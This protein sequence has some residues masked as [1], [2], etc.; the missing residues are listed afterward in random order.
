MDL[1]TVVN[2]ER[3]AFQVGYATR[4]M[5]V[6]S[7]FVENIGARLSRFGFQADI[8]PCGIVYNPLSV[9]DTIDLLLKG[10]E[11][12]VS[13]LLEN[14]GKWV[15]LRHHGSFSAATPEECLRK[16]NDRL[17][18]S[19]D[20]L[21]QADV[22]LL[23]WGTAWVY[24]HR[25]SGLVVSNCHKF[26]AADFDRSRLEVDQ[27]VA[28]Y[29]EL[30]ERLWRLNPRLR[31]LFTVS[32]VR[33]WKDGAHGNQLSKAV[34]LLAVDRLVNQFEQ[35]SYFPAYE[36]VMDELRDYRFYGE[37]MAHLSEVGVEY[38][39][40]RFKENYMTLETQAIM[41]RVDKLVRVLEHRPF[42]PDS[43]QSR[44]L[45]SRTEQELQTLLSTLRG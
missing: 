16:I 39:W 40:E 8:N 14:Q 38:I 18:D 31:V 6:G 36:I 27:I 9:A 22:L 15:S 11:F 10:K 35:V 2:I 3:P 17:R 45:Y 23:T 25:S 41:K 33:H 29:A 1:Q 4:I 21:R 44:Q 42:E 43:E 12:S 5:L 28:V 19:A 37:D 13:D 24:R 34:L 7:C 32:P 30:L 20:R 26:L